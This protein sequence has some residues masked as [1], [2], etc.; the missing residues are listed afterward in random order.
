[1]KNYKFELKLKSGEVTHVQE[2]DDQNFE[3]KIP[4]GWGYEDGNYE[5]I[6]TDQTA[7]IAEKESEKV[8]KLS[9]KDSLAALDLS[10]KLTANEVESTLKSLIALI[11]K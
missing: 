5:I 10:K 8:A 3:M 7:L 9:A 4:S 6:K 11:V 2:S 1:M